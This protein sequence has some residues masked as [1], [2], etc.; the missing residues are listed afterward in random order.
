MTSK[1]KSKVSDKQ[2]E[3]ES[4]YQIINLSKQ[5]YYKYT[6][7]FSEFSFYLK[8]YELHSVHAMLN[9][10]SDINMPPEL[11]KLKHNSE[12]HMLSTYPPDL[13]K[14]LSESYDLVSV[15][16]QTG[17]G[18]GDEGE[19]A[20]AGA[21]GT[22]DADFKSQMQKII[23][24]MGDVQVVTS[25]FIVFLNLCISFYIT[26][27]WYNIMFM[28]QERENPTKTIIRYLSEMPA[29]HPH[30]HLVVKYSLCVLHMIC[31]FL[32]THVPYFIKTYISETDG[33]V[34]FLVVFAIT[35]AIVT[36]LGELLLNSSNTFNVGVYTFL[37]V[38]YGVY[39]A[40]QDFN[41]N[42]ESSRLLV[43]Y[44]L[45]GP[46]TPLLYLFLFCVRLAWTVS[47]IRVISII[48]CVYVLGASFLTIPMSRNLYAFS[49]IHAHV[50][51]APTISVFVDFLY[52]YMIEI[53]FL[54]FFVTSIL[55]YSTNIQTNNIQSMLY[56]VTGTCI[57][58]V[59]GIFYLR[60][61]HH[62]R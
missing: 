55:N 20:G 8:L 9:V 30:V 17:D 3:L 16:A 43:K 28:Q 45:F 14:I 54:A 52:T 53:I 5:Y 46:I 29:K 62:A 27:N 11:D 4:K 35:M 2:L 50:R 32:Y 44:T 13:S 10:F 22:K 47:H 49:E 38:A 24:L 6:S 60:V 34:H 59:L 48:N 18:D 39:C 23:M 1:W 41:P 58:T 61:G 56:L 19:G 42:N 26:Y 57:A 36:Y 25:D 21:K 37:F 33:R 31:L 12:S 15:A 7:F 51:A 40:V